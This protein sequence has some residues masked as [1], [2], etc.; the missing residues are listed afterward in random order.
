MA[1][2]LEEELTCP[3]CR[4]IF[5]EPVFLPCSHSFCRACLKRWWKKKQVLKCPV[6]NNAC[7]S[8]RPPCNLALKNACEAFLLERAEPEPL[9]RLHAE[10]LKLF[11]LDHQ[12]PVCL[13]CRDSDAHRNHSFRPVSEAALDLREELRRSL[14]PLQDRLKLLQQVKGHFDHTTE[15]VLLQ[16]R[17]AET[18]MKKQF[19]ELHRFLQEEEDARIDALREEERQKVWV[20]SH[21]TEALRRE[22]AALSDVIQAAEEQLRAADAS[23]IRNHKA[24]VERVQ[25]CHL[26]DVPRLLSGALMD[27]A[28]HVGN[29][30]FRVWTKMK[31]VVS[32]RPVILD[33]NTAEAGLLLSEDLTSVRHGPR[34]ELPENPERFECH[35][36]V[37]GS[38]GFCSGAHSWSV[39]VGDSRAWLVGVAADGFRRKGAPDPSSGLWAVAFSNGEYVSI[40]P[41]GPSPL[42]PE[43][44]LKSV[45]VHLDWG[46]GRLTFTDAETQ[47]H[48][49]EFT[50]GHTEALFPLF[51]TSSDLPLRI[52]QAPSGED[53]DCVVRLDD[54]I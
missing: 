25:R 3:V 30:S 43:R 38:Q 51:H 20:L 24:A 45:S 23:F 15:H 17:Q 2:G 37:L 35:G 16:T 48:I 44:K 28:K 13:I 50:P 9:C 31:E 26:Q 7:G 21:E 14:E 47:A 52:S 19:Q 42:H 12:E 34:Q 49:Q 22:M 18:Q 5:E 40:S 54:E 10:S 8:K 33:P 46:R 41:T 36:M 1:P 53:E 4:D 32:Y 6:C 29:L 27:V 11:C 39:E